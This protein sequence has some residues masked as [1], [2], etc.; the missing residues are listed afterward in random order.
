MHKPFSFKWIY[1]IER[2]S[3]GQKHKFSN[4]NDMVSAWRNFKTIFPRPLFIIIFRPY[5]ILTGDTRV[6]FVIYCVL[7]RK[8]NDYRGFQPK[9]LLFNQISIR[10]IKFTLWH[11]CVPHLHKLHFYQKIKHYKCTRRALEWS[12]YWAVLRSEIFRHRDHP[13]TT[14]G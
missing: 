11:L 3:L 7:S 6:E 1:L 10:V 2:R 5:S 12:T 9:C 8:K 13:F 4:K 14:Q